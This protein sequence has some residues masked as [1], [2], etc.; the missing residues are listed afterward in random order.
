MI[1]QK[2]TQN[3]KAIQLADYQTPAYLVEKVDLLV[4]LHAEETRVISTV[5]YRRNPDRDKP[6]PLIL[7]GEEQILLAVKLN[8]RLLSEQDYV[9]DAEGFSLA[10]VPDTFEL[11]I[12]SEINP[13]GNTALEGLYLSQ[14]IY[15]TQCEPQGF[16]RITFYPDRPD[17][18]APFQVR[19][20]ADRVE[21]PV[22]LSNGNLIEQGA[23]AEG[24]HYAVWRDPF[25]KPSYLFA[26][27]AG[28]LVGLEDSFTT[29]SGR[30]ILLQI[31]VEARNRE[32]CDHAMLSLKKAMKWDEEVYGLEYDLDRYMIVA[33]DDF[34]MGAMENKGLNVFN[35]KYVLA[36]PELATDQDFLA[37]EGVIGHEYFHNYTGNRVT[38]RDW[39]Q[40]SLKEGLTVFRDQEFSA[41][42]HSAAVKRIDD[43]RV[44]RQHQFPEDAGPMAHP[45]RPASYVEINNFYTTTVY[46]KGAE[47]IRMQQTLL[48]PDL[49]N[50]AVR[51][52]L[53]K[54]DGQAVTTDDFVA[55]LEET[56][57]RDLTQF[58]RWYAQA[59][60]PRIQLETTYDAAT[61]KFYLTCRQSCAPTPGQP[62]KDPF[63][64]PLKVGLLGP[65]GQDLPLM[66]AGESQ[67]AGTSRV[68][69]LTAAVQ[70][71]I[72]EQIVQPPV[73][74]PLRGFSAP[75]ILDYPQPDN[76][77]AQRMAGDSDPFN[78][79]EA[80]Q[81]LATRQLLAALDTPDQPP[82]SR[83]F[84]ASWCAALADGDADQSL[85]AQLL[86]LPTEA[87]LGDQLD[88]MDPGLLHRVRMAAR[89][90]LAGAARKQLLARYQE[91]RQVQ[92]Y[93]VDPVQVG[94]RSLKNFCLGLLMHAELPEALELCLQQYEFATNMTDR[95][96]A[97]TCLAS[98]QAPQREALLEDFYQR[99]QNQ[100]LVVDKWFT[101]QATAEREDSLHQ[102]Q[103]LTKH[104]AFTREN[105]NRARSL[106]GAFASGNPAGFHRA[107][108]GGYRFLTE[109]VALLDARNPQLAARMA[110]P[111]SHWK[112]LEPQ[113]RQQMR[114]ELEGL[115]QR[116]LSRDLYEV[117]SKSLMPAQGQG[118]S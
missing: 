98:S 96:A 100:M 23:L 76:E 1:S 118:G 102:V 75:V 37:I 85:L 88:E 73:L 95:L 30:E 6:E 46:N 36:R 87:Y 21:C 83:Q 92:A 91:S 65:D 20:E 81:Q 86:T 53:R 38:C 19:I 68:L 110:L 27:V 101:L 33:V 84:V 113:R 79:W 48:G 44:L 108:G 35:S 52:Y 89:L 17:V 114:A 72:F 40:L 2:N 24:R 11:E 41:D 29:R 7:A 69:E 71:F 12:E 77:L 47:L 116:K 10:Q 70:E 57:G 14:G 63:L 56:S 74:S 109:Q 49:F 50:Q 22:L 42:L 117:V 104:P 13:A 93:G 45:V 64:I 115:Q 80:A 26:L 82:L 61:Q 51:H 4:Q 18:M 59:G 111:L 67:P 32:L 62:Q 43:V 31:Y 105:P 66:L 106:I 25:A 54:H 28:Q 112:K 103:L 107:D 34:N 94:R 58:R 9:L 90:Q 16:R 15:C 99:W 39:F 60:T 55:A 78:R 5:G 3:Y 97:L 8:G